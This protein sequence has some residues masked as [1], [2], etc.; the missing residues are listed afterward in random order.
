[1]SAGVVLFAAQIVSHS[2]SAVY[3][4]LT[5]AGWGLLLVT[6]FH[7]VPLAID[8]V[9]IRVLLPPG[10]TWWDTVLARWEGESASSLMPFGQLAGPVVMIRQLSRRAVQLQNAAAAITVNTPLQVLAQAVFAVIGLAIL[11]A[12]AR[13]DRRGAL[14]AGIL[15]ASAVLA[16]VAI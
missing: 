4:T 9:A 14:P 3:A 7:L 16:V 1:L 2:V 5:L 11:V 8:A 13:P 12:Q 15:L 10:T 6:L